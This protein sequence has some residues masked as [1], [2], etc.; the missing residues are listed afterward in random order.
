MVWLICGGYI[1]LGIIIFIFAMWVDREFNYYYNSKDLF[2]TI[3]LWPVV[4]TVVAWGFIKDFNFS[5]KNP[6]YKE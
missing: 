3:L 4:V 1:L 5:F 2:G 6:F